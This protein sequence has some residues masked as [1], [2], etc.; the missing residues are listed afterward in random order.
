[1][2]NTAIIHET[3]RLKESFLKNMNM[4]VPS[5]VIGAKQHF[6]FVN[7]IIDESLDSNLR[8]VNDISALPNKRSDVETFEEY[9]S[10]QKMQRLLMRY[11]Y[12]F[13]TDL[14]S[15]NVN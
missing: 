2:I 3:N 1:M 15:K 5:Y 10:R 11:R 6:R 4:S 14:A 9:K 7:W 13:T 12:M 8:L